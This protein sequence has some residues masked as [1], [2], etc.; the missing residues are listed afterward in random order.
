MRCSFLALSG[1][2]VLCAA[3]RA[4]QPAVPPPAAPALDRNNPLDALLM[5]WEAKMKSIQTLK[6]TVKREREDKVFNTRDIF[7][8]L[9]SSTFSTS[10]VM[11]TSA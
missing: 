1:V 10:G 7:E 5:Q 8:D 3:L 4:Q 11:R 2:L 9:R 6:A